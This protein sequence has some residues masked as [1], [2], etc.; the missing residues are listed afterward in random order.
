MSAAR[1]RLFQIAALSAT[2]LA[3]SAATAADLQSFEL[4]Q[5]GRYLA[6]AADCAACHTK[7]GGKPFAGGVALQTPFGTI[8]GANITPDPEAGIGAWTDDEF[9]AALRNGRGRGGVRLYPA[10][11]YP[12]Y[13][14]MTREDALAI[15]AYLQTV[16]PAPD[17][18]RTNRLPFPFNIRSSL[19]VWNALN[20][21]PGQLKPDP[22]QSEAWNRGR[23]LVDA[24]GHCGTC[25]TPKTFMGA[26]KQS[27]YLQGTQ[28]AGWVAP[29]ITGDNRKGI[30][31]WSIEDIASY[32][33]TGANPAAVA[34][35][36][37]G[38]EIVHA[39][40][41]MTDSDLKAIAIYLLSVSPSPESAA[42]PL[43]ATDARMA[44]GQAIYKD[45][46]AGCHTDAGRGSPGLFARLAGNP[47]VQSND[48][49]TL[50]RVVLHGSQGVATPGAPTAPAMPSFAWRLDDAQVAAVLTYV[51]NSWGNA[52]ASIAPDQVSKLRRD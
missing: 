39:S 30:G 37:M 31:G 27:A 29:D 25:H 9:V 34:T 47:A 21:R 22:T 35:G 6:V 18:V 20:F 8:L 14:K 3:A 48:P 24:L 7:P 40:S 1:T 16:Q 2:L 46:C 5:R 50:I 10:M 23:Y 44:A 19:I 43:A 45:N 15:R 38:E 13:T 11:P 41:N 36:D 49:A 33:K 17:K 52:A 26:D 12:A 32:L 51:R 42:A 28:L 4:V